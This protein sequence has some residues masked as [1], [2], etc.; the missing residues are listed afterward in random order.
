MIDKQIGIANTDIEEKSGTKKPF[1]LFSA[2]ILLPLLGIILTSVFVIAKYGPAEI[3]P[4]RAKSYWLSARGLKEENINYLDGQI[5]QAEKKYAATD[6]HKLLP[7]LE[8]RWPHLK[9]PETALSAKELEELLSSKYKEAIKGARRARLLTELSLLYL[10]QEKSYERA[11]PLIVEGEKLA[12]GQAFRMHE[13]AYNYSANTSG[14]EENPALMADLESLAI[15]ANSRDARFYANLAMARNKLGQFEKALRTAQTGLTVEKETGVPNK[16]PD[17]HT[18]L[19]IHAARAAFGLKNYSQAAQY[20]TEAIAS[21]KNDTATFDSAPNKHAN[22]ILIESMILQNDLEKALGA[23]DA[24]FMR[25]REES[26]IL[27]LKLYILKKLGRTE[28]L[29]KTMEEADMALARQDFDT[30]AQNDLRAG[31]LVSAQLHAD[32]AACA[33]P[34]D[35]YALYVTGQVKNRLGLYK[36][37]MADLKTSLDLNGSADQ[38]HAGKVYAELSKVQ[39]AIGLDKEAEKSRQA[40]LRFRKS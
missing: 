40:A 19:L 8:L 1:T 18:A 26:D 15:A 35:T 23:A 27:A 14:Q 7:L 28:Q 24:S 6:K 30:Q 17:L 21:N 12:P 29:R 9:N 13:K 25:F 38:I 4:V 2:S 5:A 3:L 37:A 31:D 32:I 20:A 10:I 39:K 22:I 33:S 11:L 16:T 36:E 34:Q